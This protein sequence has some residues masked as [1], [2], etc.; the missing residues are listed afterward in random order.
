MKELIARDLLSIGAVF[1]RP[2][3]P[4]TWASGI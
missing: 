1:L 2:E 3:E 4:F